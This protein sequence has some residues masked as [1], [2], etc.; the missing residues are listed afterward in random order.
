MNESCEVDIVKL[1]RTP[2]DARLESTDAV[3]NALKQVLVLGW[4]R[5]KCL[6]SLVLK[7]LLEVV[8][9]LTVNSGLEAYFRM[10][11]QLGVDFCHVAEEFLV[12]RKL[13]IEELHQTANCSAL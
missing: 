5:C 10:L 4:S 8:H 1:K 9:V 7:D 12:R 6:Q 11:C 3:G 13:V 2:S